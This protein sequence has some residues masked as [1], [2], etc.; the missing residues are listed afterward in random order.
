MAA[1]VI[2]E[3]YTGEAPGTPTDITYQNTVAQASD[4]HVS[5]E[6]D[7]LPIHVPFEGFN[8]SYWVSTRLNITVAPVGLITNVRWYSDGSNSLGI[9]ITC[10]GQTAR[11]GSDSGYR[12]ATG[13]VGVTGTVLS[14]A[15]HSGLTAEPVSVFAF[16]AASPKTMTVSTSSI[17]PV[18]DFFV[19]QMRV[20]SDLSSGVTPREAFTWAYDES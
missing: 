4:V 5:D 14:V 18:G 3:R 12:Q 10:I 19:Y 13:T 11:L 9:G 20:S 8:Y 6:S 17:G 7:S 16:T 1:T 15:N 2:I